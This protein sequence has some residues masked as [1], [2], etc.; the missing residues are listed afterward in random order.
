MT[1]EAPTLVPNGGYMQMEMR[2]VGFRVV[3]LTV[4]DS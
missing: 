1:R 4:E 3:R 2:I